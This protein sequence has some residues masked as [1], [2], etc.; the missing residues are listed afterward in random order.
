MAPLADQPSEIGFCDYTK[1]K[2]VEITLPGE[3]LPPLLAACGGVPNELRTIGR[4]W[5]YQRD[6]VPHQRRWDDTAKPRS[7]VS[8]FCE[9][10]LWQ[11]C[12]PG[13]RRC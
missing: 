3:S 13:R 2:R 6:L 7:P 10:G 4:P 9:C 12:R 8:S 1:A 5:H 11:A